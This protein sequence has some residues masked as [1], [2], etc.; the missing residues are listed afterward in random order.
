[1]KEKSPNADKNLR[2]IKFSTNLVR[3]NLFLGLNY[4]DSKMSWNF[5]DNESTEFCRKIVQVHFLR[6]LVI[7]L[8]IL[9][10]IDDLKQCIVENVVSLNVYM[11]MR[12]W[13]EIDE[14]PLY[15]SCDT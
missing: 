2:K 5:F 8:H 12:V 6:S 9:N 13:Q 3:V 7:F 11:L 4:T 10:D 15:I 1:M 14:H